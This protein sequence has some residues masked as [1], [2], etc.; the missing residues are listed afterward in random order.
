MTNPSSLGR[1]PRIVRAALAVAA[2]LTIVTASPALG[3]SQVSI[4]ARAL[5]GGRYEV[6]GWVAVAV[7]LVN[8]GAPTEGTLLAEADCLLCVTRYLSGLVAR[9]DGDAY[10]VGTRIAASEELAVLLG[11]EPPDDW[12]AE[13]PA[14]P[15]DLGLLR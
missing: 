12:D 15:D 3:A 6:G 8:E 10:A 4:E 14:A 13:A 11:A 1:V 9:L 7:T 5:V 2:L